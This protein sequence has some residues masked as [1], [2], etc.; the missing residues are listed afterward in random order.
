MDVNGCEV[1]NRIAA[2]WRMFWSMKCLFTH[3]EASIKQKME[4]FDATVSSCAFWC[5]ESWTLGST[6]RQQLQEAQRA[7]LRRIERVRRITDEPY[8]DWN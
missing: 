6:E 5:A 7:M 3:S 8:V 1:P 4:L 2:S